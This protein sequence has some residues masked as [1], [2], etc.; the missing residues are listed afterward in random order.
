[1][2]FWL[3]RFCEQ[4][5]LLIADPAYHYYFSSGEVKFPFDIEYINATIKHLMIRGCETV[6]AVLGMTSILSSISNQ[7]GYLMRSFLLI[8]DQEDRNI[9]TVSAVLFLVLALQTGLTGMD[10]ENR[11][12][13]LYRNLCLISSA[14]LHFIHNVV[15]P[16]LLSLSVSRN[17]SINKH[18]RALIT[19][20]FLMAFPTWFVYYLW[21][22]H[23][24]STWLLAVSCF[25]VEVIL[26]VIIIIKIFKYLIKNLCF[27]SIF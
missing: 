15:N 16:L 21:N 11:F 4:A 9:G 20:I 18:S 2:I 12:L 1:M 17:M 26:K 7:I 24:L 13:R 8:E 23:P 25:S 27:F 6:I 22:D 3:T 14:I 5:I 10:P 19:C